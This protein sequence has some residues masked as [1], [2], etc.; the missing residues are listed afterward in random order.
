MN[1][2]LAK[3]IE[4]YGEDLQQL[5]AW[6]LC[7]GFVLCRPECFAMGFFVDSMDPM[8]PVQR[9]EANALFV[10]YCAGSMQHCLVEF[11]KEFEFVAFQRDTKSSP[12]VRVWDYQKTLNRIK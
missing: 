11:N 2:H 7:H 5:L 9:E 6:H 8:S 1:H 3:A 10:T 12:N 4:I